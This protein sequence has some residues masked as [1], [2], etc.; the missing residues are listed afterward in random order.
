MNKNLDDFEINILTCY[1]LITL[2]IYDKNTNKKCIKS[3]VKSKIETIPIDIKYSIDE[4]YNHCLSTETQ[5]ITI[6][7]TKYI[8]EIIFLH[9]NIQIFFKINIDDFYDIHQEK[10]INKLNDIEK[11]IVNIKKY[12][13]NLIPNIGIQ[14]L[15]LAYFAF[16]SIERIINTIYKN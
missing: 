7:K 2:D 1:N 12:E 4:I 8:L 16:T 14:H 6:N 15:I 10:I 13:I 5:N 9:N 3:F 11:S